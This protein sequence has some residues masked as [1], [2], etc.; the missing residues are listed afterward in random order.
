MK[1]V[2]MNKWFTPRETSRLSVTAM[3][4][5]HKMEHQLRAQLARRPYRMKLV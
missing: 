2:H 5:L 1:A 3:L 4:I